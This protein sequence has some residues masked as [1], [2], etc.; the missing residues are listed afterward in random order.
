M[1]PTAVVNIAIIAILAC[2][3]IAVL[4]V[5]RKRGKFEIKGPLGTGLNIDA[6]NDPAPSTPGVKVEN[7][8]S[9]SGGL[10]A[11][12]Y[13]GR[14][15]EVKNVETKDDILVSSTPSKEIKPSKKS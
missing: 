2:I 7:A 3:I 12:D 9:R 11:E 5:F 13:T 6:S 10:L 14:G 1:D 8:T 4:L 15:A